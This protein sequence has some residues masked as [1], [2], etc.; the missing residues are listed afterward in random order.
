M[1]SKKAFGVAL[2]AA[3]NAKTISKNKNS[4]NDNDE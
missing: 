4:N 1:S 2:G 3:L